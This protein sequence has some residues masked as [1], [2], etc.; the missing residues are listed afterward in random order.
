[1]AA[2]EPRWR[3]LALLVSIL[4][5]FTVAP[6]VVTHRHGII[7]MNVV[8]TAVLIAGSYALSEPRHVFIIAIVLSALSVAGTSLLAAFPETRPSSFRTLLFSCSEDF[9]VSP[10]F[11]TS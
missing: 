11:P 5:L 7:I 8:S 4:L 2:S 6:F 10:F 3:H 9:F 1:M